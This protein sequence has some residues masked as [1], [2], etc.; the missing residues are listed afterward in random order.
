MKFDFTHE[1]A[2][3]I[4]LAVEKQFRRQKMKTRF[5]VKPFP[6]APYRP[7]LVAVKSGLTIIVEAQGNLDYHKTLAGFVSWLAAGRHYVRFYIATTEHSTIYATTLAEMKKHG[8]GWLVVEES[9]IITESAKARNPALVVTPDPNLRYGDCQSEVMAAL[10]K[11]NDDNRKD[12]LRDMCEIVERETKALAVI[13][14]RRNLLNM[15][16]TAIEKMSWYDQINALASINAYN[17]GHNPILDDP[18]KHDLHSFRGARNL[19]DHPVKN[20]REDKRRELQFAER[21]V[22]GPRLVAELVRLRR[23]NQ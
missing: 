15:S 5:E 7:T 23:R 21:M 18:F 10:K 8:V 22:Q 2:Q 3:P 6:D 19:V 17:A 1:E 16:Q 20:R 11:F 14:V 12:G 13:G 4:A 9:R